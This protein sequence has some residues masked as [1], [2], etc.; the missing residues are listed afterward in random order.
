[1]RLILASASPRRRE[2]LATLGLEFDVV[3]SEA[4]ETFPAHLN[5]R[6]AAVHLARE[7]GRWVARLRPDAWV[8]SA[9]TIVVVEG[10][11]L[12]KPRD[13][14]E[15][16]SMLTRLSGRTHTV[17]TAFC[18]IHASLK[19]ERCEAVETQVSFRAV[20]P[21]ELAAYARSGEPLDKAGAYA[22]QGGAAGFVEAVEGSYSNV[23]GL[24][25]EKL[26]EVLREEGILKA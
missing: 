4:D 23:V 6:E 2:L 18:L 20:A 11:I 24:P 1:M 9:D 22:I 19:R 26:S 5:P 14:E 10:E 21:G 12:G 17:I 8:L 25:L 15:A 16:L 13:A 3:P 7:K